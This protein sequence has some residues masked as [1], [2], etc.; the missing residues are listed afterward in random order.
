M[1][2]EIVMYHYVRPHASTEFPKIQGLD[3]EGFVR[4]MDFFYENKNVVSTNDVLSAFNGDL[5]LPD[6]AVWLTFDDGYKDHYE[7][8]APVLEKYGFNAAF[9]PVSDTYTSDVLLDVNAIH[10]ILACHASNAGLLALLRE[11]MLNAGF[12]KEEIQTLWKSVKEDPKFNEKLKH[13]LR[14]ESSNETP[15]Y[16]TE[17]VLIFKRTLQ[18]TLPHLVRKKII[19]R[20]FEMVV[21]MSK[22]SLAKKL[23]MSKLELTSLVKRGFTVGSHTSSHRWLSH[24]TYDEQ[25]E[26]IDNSLTSLREI[27]GSIDNWIF[28]YPCGAYNAD[29]LDILSKKN[30]SL[31]L[32]TKSGAAVVSYNNRFELPRLDTNDLPQ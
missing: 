27:N 17:I 9:F 12:T 7:Y 3:I 19:D 21:G 11:E 26:E 22:Q 5:K 18:G 15:S 6:N 23:Y 16:D 14:W 31:G 24:L 8:A 29:T 13:Y 32:T 30:C 1:Q 2:L 25:L 28:C 4:Q 20:I 10:H